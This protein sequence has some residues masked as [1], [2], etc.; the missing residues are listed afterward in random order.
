MY[1]HSWEKRRSLVTL[2]STLLD[3]KVLFFLDKSCLQ[4]LGS[5]A[6]LFFAG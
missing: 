4:L 1:C 5:Q 3:R 6:W 2:L